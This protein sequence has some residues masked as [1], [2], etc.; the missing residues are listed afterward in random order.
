MHI[1]EF[2]IQTQNTRFFWGETFFL[3]K[4]SVHRK[5]AQKLTFIKHIYRIMNQ[6]SLR[7]HFFIILKFCLRDKF[8]L[9][10]K[11]IIFL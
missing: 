8:Y 4:M 5:C 9:C 3:G 10:K 6:N 2:L 1:I 7:E 11:N